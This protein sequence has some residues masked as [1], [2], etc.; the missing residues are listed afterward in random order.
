MMSIKVK[1][2]RREARRDVSYDE[3]EGICYPRHPHVPA[4]RTARLE[5]RHP[6]LWH[7]N[8]FPG[9][10][11]AA[12]LERPDAERPCMQLRLSGQSGHSGCRG[13]Q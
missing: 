11:I 9:F 10:R 7:G 13:L 3:E 6:L 5:M 2:V 4:A 1:D 8:C 12:Y